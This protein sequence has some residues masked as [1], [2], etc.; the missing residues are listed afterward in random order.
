MRKKNMNS[1]EVAAAIDSDNSVLVVISSVYSQ[2]TGA[3]FDA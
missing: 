2:Q 3:P 1:G